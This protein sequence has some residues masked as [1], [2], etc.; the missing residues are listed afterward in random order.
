MRTKN[1]FFSGKINSY[2]R[3]IS[4]DYVKKTLKESFVFVVL[5][6]ARYIWIKMEKKMY[7]LY[8]TTLVMKI[9]FE[10]PLFN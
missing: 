9:G 6:E 7:F 5:L 10:E 3:S 2:A 8:L 1:C 4:S